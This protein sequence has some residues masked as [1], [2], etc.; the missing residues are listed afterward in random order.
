MT[1]SYTTAR[2]KMIEKYGTNW[3]FQYSEKE[4][5]DMKNDP[6]RWWPLETLLE[7]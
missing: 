5:N 2:E 6:N 7:E 1:G 4:W 3:G